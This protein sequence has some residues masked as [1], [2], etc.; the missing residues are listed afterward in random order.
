MKIFNQ[1]CSKIVGYDNVLKEFQ[2][3]K[4]KQGIS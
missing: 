1:F 2:F 3:N 4:Q